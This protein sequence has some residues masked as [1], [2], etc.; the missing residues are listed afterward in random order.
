VAMASFT[1]PA[2]Q[3]LAP[4][5]LTHNVR[6][7]EVLEACSV[8]GMVGILHQLGELAAHAHELFA[9]LTEEAGSAAERVS[10]LSIRLHGATEDLARVDDALQSTQ[11]EELIAICT[12]GP[13]IEYHAAAEVQS[14]LFVAETRPPAL[15][16]AF[17]AAR[18]PP[19]L[20]LLDS[21]VPKPEGGG[22]YA[23]YNLIDTCADGW[24]DK[25]FFL[26]QWLDEEER[27]VNALKA[28]RSLAS[29]RWRLRA[30]S[31]HTRTPSPS[32]ITL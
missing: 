20:D 18:R 6:D 25:H 2:A 7:D 19:K 8:A 13:G 9:G 17:E 29:G 14:N 32:P 27:K 12:E 28:V 5:A 23:K 31:A 4:P 3:T 11:E 26:K 30:L 1:I 21:F 22:K 16:E 24:S 10:N 15:Q